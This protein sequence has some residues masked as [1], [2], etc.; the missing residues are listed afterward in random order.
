MTHLAN[1]HINGSFF[2][3]SYTLTKIIGLMQ[4]HPDQYPET[5]LV[6]SSHSSVAGHP[7]FVINVFSKMFSA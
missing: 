3:Q 2:I 1:D 4:H 5:H 6:K 7:S